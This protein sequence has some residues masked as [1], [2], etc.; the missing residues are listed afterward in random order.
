[1]QLRARGLREVSRSLGDYLLEGEKRMTDEP[2]QEKKPLGQLIDE[3]ADGINQA[4]SGDG[5]ESL[6]LKVIRLEA[7]NAVLREQIAS[8]DKIIDML[9][10]QAKHG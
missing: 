7:E 4:I 9:R 10:Q 8:K 1:M 3:V 2:K 5:Y 6:T